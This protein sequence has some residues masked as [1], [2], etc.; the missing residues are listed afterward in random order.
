MNRIVRTTSSSPQPG[1]PCPGSPAARTDPEAPAPTPVATHAHPPPAPADGGDHPQR[2]RSASRPDCRFRRSASSSACT[3]SGSSRTA[4]CRRPTSATPAGTTVGPR[5][6][7][8]GPAVLVAHVHGPAGDDVFARLHDL[9][10][11]D[12][13]TVKRTD[14][15]STFVVESVEQAAKDAAAARADLERHR[16]PRAAPDHLRRQARSGDPY[17]SGQHD[18]LRP[19]GALTCGF[20][21]S[22]RTR[23]KNFQ[24]SCKDAMGVLLLHPSKQA[25]DNATT[26]APPTN[27][28]T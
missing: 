3:A 26:A 27:R 16:R 9:E 18:R 15:S 25:P 19:N 21:R 24:K 1:R 13:V 22:K 12:Q 2:A 28:R 11:G 8:P 5:P 20:E 6:G 4:R 23:R 10:P 14:G 7:A 17:V